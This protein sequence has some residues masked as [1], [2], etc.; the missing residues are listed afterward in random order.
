[1][2]IPRDQLG[3]A[4]HTALRK[5]CDSSWANLV[6]SM[7]YVIDSNIWDAFLD[8]LH[9]AFERHTYSANTIV[10]VFRNFDYGRRLYDA[11]DR[12]NSMEAYYHYQEMDRRLRMDNETQW[13]MDHGFTIATNMI[14]SE[15]AEAIMAALEYYFREEEAVS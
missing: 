11:C 5:Y 13:R 15:D 3:E 8:T 6:H 2:N 7:I 1:M 9:D 4:I 14:T 10:T 12:T